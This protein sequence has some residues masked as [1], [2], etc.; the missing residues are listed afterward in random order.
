MKLTAKDIATAGAGDGVP[1]G[2]NNMFSQM[3]AV[4]NNA[5]SLIQ[6]IQ[7]TRGLG[8]APAGNPQAQV[9][10]TEPRPLAPAPAPAAAPAGPNQIEAFVQALVN[11]GYGDR[12]V[13][14]LLGQIAPLTVKEIQGFLENA[15]T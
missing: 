15:R 11:N 14:D 2:G 3:N 13:G 5:K 10:I 7:N 1:A 6:L 4:I 8:Q 9:K 12:T